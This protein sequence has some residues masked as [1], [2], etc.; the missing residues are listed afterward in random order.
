MSD[1]QRFAT[2]LVNNQD[3]KGTPDFETVAAAFK[4]LDTGVATA[5]VPTGPTA[6]VIPTP[7]RALPDA[8]ERSLLGEAFV[9]PA[10]QVLKGAATGVRF[11]TDTLGADNP[12]S[13]TIGG[14]ED[15][16]DS[17][18]SA[19]AKR[20]QQE[21]S[22]ILKEAE[23][24][25]MGAQVAA[26]LSALAT[27]P[28]D[29]IANAFGTAV[30]T[31]AAGLAGRA[32]GLGAKAVATG[33]GALT[34]VGVT[35][36][37]VYSAVL[38]ELTNAGVP[39][40]QAK[41][42][43]K[44]AQAYGGEN[45]DNIALGGVLGAVAAR[46]GLEDTLLSR[47][48]QK[49]ASGVSKE[50]VEQAAKSGL[51]KEASRKALEEAIPEAL[52][53][54][55][56]QFAQNIALQR[57]GFDVPTFRGVTAGAT[58]EGA[59]GAPVG[60]LGEV[61]PAAIERVRDA[62]S[63]IDAEAFV[64]ELAQQE[65]ERRTT[66]REEREAAQ[67]KKEEEEA[68]AEAAKKQEEEFKERQR[69]STQEYFQRLDEASGLYTARAFQQMA[70]EAYENEQPDE[71]QRRVADEVYQEA[72]AQGL[73]EDE[74]IFLSDTRSEEA[75]DEA[76]RRQYERATPR[77]E[78]EEPITIDTEG[79]LAPDE[80]KAFNSF[81]K[82]LE[83]SVK[84]KSQAEGEQVIDNLLTTVVE[85]GAEKLGLTGASEESYIR[86]SRALQ[87]TIA[88]ADN[89]LGSS[90]RDGLRKAKY[91]SDDTEVG[92]VLDLMRK[93]RFELKAP[94]K[95]T[96]GEVK[97]KY[98]KIDEKA[99]TNIRQ[100]QAMRDKIYRQAF[101]MKPGYSTT[102]AAG[103]KPEQKDPSLDLTKRAEAESLEETYEAVS[104]RLSDF[105][106]EKQDQ[107]AVPD[108]LKNIFRYPTCLIQ[109][110]R[111]MN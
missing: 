58:L 16:F 93:S 50:G 66:L 100:A 69:K 24:K 96:L 40:E 95:D 75:Y 81:I 10:A 73:T 97:Q 9:D 105:T 53:G 8:R 13:R 102:I 1:L 76:L 86:K 72:I 94:L 31:L 77:A 11:L 29:L 78:R 91:P 39:E 106:E 92:K 43:A 41:E 48:G 83:D 2:W 70:L 15:F 82:T 51:I 56:E 21:I 20:D 57:E 68:A 61:A 3:K 107:K 110:L 108:K 12:L 25:G 79:D 47:V 109:S 37:A 80:L 85:E 5:P 26:G 88:I 98:G 67:K 89:M 59:V 17:L 30:P 104:D 111:C 60:A 63:P 34:G 55:Q 54:G 42:A 32:V 99:L 44:E 49:L 22:R 4:K 6:P 19:Q 33:V 23:D 28:V 62:V 45:L 103:K 18:L 46:F 71:V 87:E 14:A 27:A 84:D 90:I 7:S 65:Q 52:Q 38:E 64:E 36:D 74:A 101:T 35:K